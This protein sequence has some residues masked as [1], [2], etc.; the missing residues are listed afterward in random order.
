[1]KTILP[2]DA[3]YLRLPGTDESLPDFIAACWPD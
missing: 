1:M 2:T 3:D